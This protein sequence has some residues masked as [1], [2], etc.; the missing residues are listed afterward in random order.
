MAIFFKTLGFG[1]Y[2]WTDEN[3]SFRIANDT[4]LSLHADVLRGSSRVPDP[5][6]SAEPKDRFLSHCSQTS[7]GDH[8][9]ITGDPIVSQSLDKPNTYV[10][11]L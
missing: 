5:R 3:G 6:S 4:I 8:M 1:L 7:D 9:K 10:Q 11:G 2:V